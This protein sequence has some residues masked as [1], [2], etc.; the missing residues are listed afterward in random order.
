MFGQLKLGS[1]LGVNDAKSR[2][3][4]SPGINLHPKAHQ[5]GATARSARYPSRLE[6]RCHAVCTTMGLVDVRGA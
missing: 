4:G 3:V 6:H 2:K 1:P 5:L